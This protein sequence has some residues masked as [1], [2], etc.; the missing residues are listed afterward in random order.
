MSWGGVE[1]PASIQGWENLRSGLSERLFFNPYD[2][3]DNRP[4]GVWADVEG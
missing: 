3:E 2:F 1:L 4:C